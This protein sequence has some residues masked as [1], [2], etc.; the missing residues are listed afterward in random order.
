MLPD[1]QLAL[2]KL[3]V[4]RNLGRSY[5]GLLAL[6]E[7]LHVLGCLND[8][9]YKALKERYS[10]KLECTVVVAPE[11]PRPPH[12]LSEAKEQARLKKIESN[13]SDVIK[14]WN[15]M[16]PQSRDYWVKQAEE[17]KDKVS[18]AKMV[19]A[20]ASEAGGPIKQETLNVEVS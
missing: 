15:T 4:D 16:K 12:T 14:Q 10:Q 5:S 19:L 18:N 1:L 13:L 2:A 3:Q 7:G 20:L 8:A 6:T 17:Y 11:Q 9:A